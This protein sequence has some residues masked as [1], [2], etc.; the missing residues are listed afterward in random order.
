M[1][2]KAINWKQFLVRRWNELLPHLLEKKELHYTEVANIW[3]VSTSTARAWLMRLV[4]LNLKGLSDIIEYTDGILRLKIDEETRKKWLEEISKPS[5]S[6]YYQEMFEYVEAK[7]EYEKTIASE[8][9]D[10]G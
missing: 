5:E 3:E 2:R 9:A 7:D 1:G 8:N 4:N 10:Q 6:K